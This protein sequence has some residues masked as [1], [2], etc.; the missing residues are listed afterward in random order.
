MSVQLTTTS[1]E[2]YNPNNVKDNYNSI[3]FKTN[4]TPV[5]NAVIHQAGRINFYSKS[6]SG[7]EQETAG[8]RFVSYTSNLL[9]NVTYGN[10][11]L[12]GQLNNNGAPV[13]YCALDLSS[14]GSSRLFGGQGLNYYS[15]VNG[16]GGR[17]QTFYVYNSDYADYIRVFSIATTPTGATMRWYPDGTNLMS[18][19]VT[20]LV[21]GTTSP[22]AMLDVNSTKIRLR[23]ANTPASATAA[24]NQ[25]D[26]CWD[27]NYVYVCVATN[28]WKRS[29]LAS[30]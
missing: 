24:G 25:G 30:W 9:T 10:L 28:T 27:A 4:Y 3:N 21:L 13:E 22:T 7:L 17:S 23:T 1:V 19:T 20:G 18:L 5:G 29:A 26:I 2:N 8:I 14:T 11:Y 12:F 6:P 15:G 16:V